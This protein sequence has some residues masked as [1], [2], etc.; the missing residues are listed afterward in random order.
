MKKLVK[1]IV[2]RVVREQLGDAEIASVR[3]AE[4]I[5]FNG[6]AILRVTVLLT[7]NELLD[8]S[9]TAGLVRHL[10]HGLRSIGEERFPIVSYV[11]KADA[12][13]LP[14]EAA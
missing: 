4:D 3:V 5:D 13:S 6:D 2:E 10:R 8:P 12:K 7:K 14:A 9:K 11:S 1:A